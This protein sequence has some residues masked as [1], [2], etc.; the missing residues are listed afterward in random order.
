MEFSVSQTVYSAPVSAGF[1]FSSFKYPGFPLPQIFI[2]TER[3]Q[4]RKLST[5]NLML[6]ILSG[7]C[8]VDGVISG[9]L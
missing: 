6:V 7:G 2:W 5:F 1:I 4:R 3:D 8:S 9:R